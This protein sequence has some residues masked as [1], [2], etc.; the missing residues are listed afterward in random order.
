MSMFQ[1]SGTGRQRVSIV[2]L[3]AMGNHKA[4][5]CGQEG[6]RAMTDPL[7]LAVVAPLGLAVLLVCLRAIRT[8]RRGLRRR[9]CPSVF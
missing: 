4:G 5:A 3:L 8:S 9:W 2:T 6:C 7:V 1:R